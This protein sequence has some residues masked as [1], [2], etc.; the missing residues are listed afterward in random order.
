MCG[1]VTE[2]QKFNDRSNWE[3]DDDNAVRDISS[4]DKDNTSRT[5]DQMAMGHV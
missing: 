1:N 2:E 3:F 5:T 4:A